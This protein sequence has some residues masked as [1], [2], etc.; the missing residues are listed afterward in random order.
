MHI[1]CFGV[2][3]WTNVL[4]SCFWFATGHNQLKKSRSFFLRIESTKLDTSPPGALDTSGNSLTRPK[5]LHVLSIW[6]FGLGYG[7]S[8][9]LQIE[10]PRQLL[11]FPARRSRHC[12][13]GVIAGTCR[14]PKALG[15]SS[16]LNAESADPTNHSGSVNDKQ[17]RIMYY[18]Q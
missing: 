13:V 16:A 4:L 3:S 18:S 9:P 2:M 1:S 14:F 8:S 11:I 7:P 10:A 12:Y 5:L 6:P 17:K 15:R